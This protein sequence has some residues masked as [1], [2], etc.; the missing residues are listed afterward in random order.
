MNER[1]PQLSLTRTI[2]KPT[3]YISAIDGEFAEFA[4]NEERA[5]Q[6]QGAWR[7]NVFKVE[8]SVPLDLEF[9]TGNGQHFAH[10]ANS[11]PNRCLV[12]FELKYKPLIQSIRR[13]LNGGAK[14]A[15]IL[16]YHAH[17]ADLAFAEGE[18]NNVYVH[19]P[20][21][22]ERPKK[23]KNRI[24]CETFLNRLYKLQRPGSFV[25][26]KTDSREYF[27]WALEEIKKTNYVLEFHTLDLHQSEMASENFITTFEKIFLGEGIPINACRLRKPL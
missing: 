23:F 2:P 3:Y 6:N 5:P 26:F 17:N 27:L 24:I 19:F 14:N 12:G 22:W 11:N 21:P 10:H 9:G 7:S 16:R 4:F 13:T 25:E 20:D 15:R 1:R 18:I 8:D